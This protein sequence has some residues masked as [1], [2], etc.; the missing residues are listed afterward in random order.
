[1][2]EVV[3]DRPWSEIAKDPLA[4]LIDSQHGVVAGWQARRFLSEKAIRHRVTSGRWRRVRRGLF[5][6]Y[7]G[8]IN[9]RQRQWIA[10][11]AAGP[12]TGDSR[13]AC[14]GGLSAL[15]VHGLRGISADRVHLIVPARRE[16]TPPAGVLVHRMRLIEEDRHP[17]SR[18][19]TTTLARAVVDAAAWARS[20]DEAR[21]IVAAS[22]QQ[23]LVTVAEIEI[24]LDRMP[25]TRRRL[26]VLTTARDAGG[27]SHSL[28]ELMLLD[29]CRTFRLPLPTRQLRIPDLDGRIRHI[30]GVFDPWRVAV[31]IDGAHHAEVAHAWDDLE[32]ENEL[33][34][35]G[36][37]VLRF[38]V[39]VVREQPRKVAQ[40]IRAA[41]E[42]AGWRPDVRPERGGGGRSQ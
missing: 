11:L 14:L 22:I 29:I 16:V 37:R 3:E 31:E 23:R 26:L 6:V 15:Q 1:M 17:W 21:L 30:D 4:A 12:S 32:R 13:A 19:P 35:A 7:G 28:G 24:A 39:H 20:D 2:G 40:R 9:L 36:Y 38:P 5:L 41:L 34:L 25:S 18:P 33:V 8:P 27:G 10:V 42:L